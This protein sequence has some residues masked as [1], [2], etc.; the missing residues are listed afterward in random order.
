MK[1]FIIAM[2]I[3][4]TGVAA[5]SARD[6]YSRDI[7][8]LPAAA[9]NFIARNFKAKVNLIK[10]DSGTFSSTDYDVILTDG[11]EIDFDSAGNWKDI[12]APPPL[13]ETEPSESKNRRH[14]ARAL[15]L[16][17]RALRRHRVRDRPRRRLQ[18]LRRLTTW[19][20]LKA[21]RPPLPALLP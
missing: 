16:Q 13:C 19:S 20:S 4:L 9:Q 14:R 10:I 21:S 11:S 12:E 18:A 7:K 17:N 5:A 3:M 2:L 1:K 6:S 8:V 15:G